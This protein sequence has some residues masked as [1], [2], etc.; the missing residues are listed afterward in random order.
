MT[1]LTDDDVASLVREGADP[2]LKAAARAGR[3]DKVIQVLAGGPALLERYS[4]PD[5]SQ[6][7]YGAAIVEAALAA[8][9]LGH[10]APIARDLLTSGAPGFLDYDA[11]GG[12]PPANWA[13]LGLADATRPVLGI[14]ALEPGIRGEQHEIQGY[15]PHNYLEQYYSP[16]PAGQL[17]P[18]SLWDA[19]A[20]HAANV[21]RTRLAREADRRGLYRYA[22]LIAIPAAE[23]G[24]LSAM[25]LL[26]G[27]FARA[28][29]AAE[30][31]QWLRR[32]AATGS[33][34]DQFALVRLLQGGNRPDEAREWVRREQ[35]TW[36]TE[37]MLDSLG[38]LSA[39]GDSDLAEDWLQSRAE[40]DDPDALNRLIEYRGPEACRPWIERAAE[41]GDPYFMAEMAEL[42]PEEAEQWYRRAAAVGSEDGQWMLAMLLWKTG[43]LA[44]A[45][46]IAR[47]VVEAT[48]QD[49]GSN[50]FEL[51]A[52]LLQEADRPA[53]AARWL[54]RISGIDDPE[55][56]GEIADKLEALDGPAA[57]E[58]WLRH[59]AQEDFI[60]QLFLTSWLQDHGRASEAESILRAEHEA[61][62]YFARMSLH[63][64]LL[65][66]GR[67]ADAENLLRRDSEAG[68]PRMMAELARLLEKTNRRPEARQWWQRASQA[69]DLA[70]IQR[71]IEI[72][73][74]EGR[75][76]EADRELR[77][78]AQA[79]MS[80]ALQKLTAFL[81]RT[82]KEDE[83]GR[84]AQFGIEPRRRSLVGMVAVPT[85]SRAAAGRGRRFPR[86]S[87]SSWPLTEGDAELLYRE[88]AQCC[89]RPP[90]ARDGWR[91]LSTRR[92]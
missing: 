7:R 79:G 53:E 91:G 75:T 1:S 43:R 69:D 68:S 88:P 76:D 62:N 29:H 13:D 2:R 85:L 48:P 46:P 4:D 74:E 40:A 81:E 20:E 25:Q 71:Q 8:R 60:V 24:S 82:G 5:S 30:A 34:N 39:V 90:G 54:Q 49:S 12:L 36:T 33:A 78:L 45:E 38:L 9:R 27:A 41:Q 83:A 73:E 52:D 84:I 14:P 59:L 31:E 51:Y 61:G 70:A 58:R 22:V 64:Y 50:V 72:L 92:C 3:R 28:G 56:L 10:E 16:G 35:A 15:L 57:A 21:D 32:A 67:Y 6:A 42:E 66:S 18:R 86:K 19:L 11:P 17:P 63:G 47:A 80:S 26:A 37:Q 23:R 44:E 77:R 65:N 55:T 89:W 87:L